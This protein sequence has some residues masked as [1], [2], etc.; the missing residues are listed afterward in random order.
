MSDGIE[1]GGSVRPQTESGRD[2]RCL[3]PSHDL[4]SRAKLGVL[5]IKFYSVHC[6]TIHIKKYVT[7]IVQCFMCNAATR[8]NEKISN[9]LTAR[10]LPVPSCEADSH[11][12]E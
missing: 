8:F 7:K 12:E 5:A 4:I 10:L 6:I 11:L 9:H 3:F 2:R 1:E